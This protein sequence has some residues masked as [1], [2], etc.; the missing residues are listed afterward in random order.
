MGDFD[1]TYPLLAFLSSGW[2]V[3]ICLVYQPGFDRMMRE[4]SDG[5]VMNVVTPSM[6]LMLAL[7]LN[8]L[9]WVMGYFASCEH[10]EEKK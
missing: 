1:W 10:I 5:T 8:V 4:V 2:L 3:V 7:M 9:G 6:F